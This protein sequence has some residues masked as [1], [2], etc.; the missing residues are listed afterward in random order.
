ML[1]LVEKP[2]DLVLSPDAEAEG[3][4][5]VGLDG[6]LQQWLLLSQQQRD[7]FTSLTAS[8]TAAASTLDAKNNTLTERFTA[9]AKASR[10]EAAKATQVIDQLDNVT[11]Q[12]TKIDMQSI[13]CMADDLV[14]D[15][16][17][18]VMGL[19]RNA[20]RM[21]YSL[22]D[23]S[24]SLGATETSIEGIERINRQTIMLALNARIEAER[25]GPAGSTFKVVADEVKALSANTESMATNLRQQIDSIAASAQNNDSVLRALADIDIS[26]FVS[27]RNSI[28][29]L[30]ERMHL[31]A[32]D[33]ALLLGQ[34]GSSMQALSTTLDA[35]VADMQG[36]SSMQPLLQQ[37]INTL[38]DLANHASALEKHT[39]DV[40]D[41][42]PPVQTS[43][44]T[45]S[46]E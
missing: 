34:L 41:T 8:L 33:S 9:M 38:A 36:N 23:V 24:K 46:E 22:E 19:A 18:A 6:L 29:D 40:L 27:T 14:N 37:A 35:L 32:K 3:T 20:M 21:V 11:V 15:V 17:G 2:D 12:G 10:S 30:N 31:Q 16:I 43:A 28:R 44:P 42:S 1:K 13:T 45:I 5:T 4:E 39:A 7:D 26:K 25:A